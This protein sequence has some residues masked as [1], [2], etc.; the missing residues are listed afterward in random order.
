L[1]EINLKELNMKKLIC[2]ND[3][4]VEIVKGTDARSA[5]VYAGDTFEVTLEDGYRYFGKLHING[6]F[7]HEP[8]LSGKRFSSHQVS[9][10]DSIVY[11]VLKDK[12]T[13]VP[14]PQGFWATWEIISDDK[15]SNLDQYPPIEK[16]VPTKVMKE[17][18][19]DYTSINDVYKSTL[20]SGEIGIG[21]KVDGEVYHMTKDQ[22]L[23]LAHNLTVVANDLKIK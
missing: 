4:R 22:A 15:P 7:S 16:A 18:Y 3:G 2:L 21:L 13:N 20:L 1:D 19:K 23:L 10:P 8:G 17:E 6:T 12:I 5:D 11:A 14:D 9:N